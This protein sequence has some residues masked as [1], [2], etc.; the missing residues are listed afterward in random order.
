M[1]YIDKVLFASKS[2]L[3][4]TTPEGVDPTTLEPTFTTAMEVEH[5]PPEA[6]EESGV[7]P[8]VLFADAEATMIST[9]L[10]PEIIK[11]TTTKNETIK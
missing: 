3:P 9:E 8:D 2:S 11:S 6:V 4:T 7:L 1:F 10:P 5:V